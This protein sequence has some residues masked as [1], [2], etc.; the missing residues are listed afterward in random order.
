MLVLAPPFL[1]CSLLMKAPDGHRATICIA[2]ALAPPG[3]SFFIPPMLPECKAYSSYASGIPA[4]SLPRTKSTPLLALV[5]FSLGIALPTPPFIPARSS[6]NS[7]VLRQAALFLGVFHIALPVAPPRA[8]PC[9]CLP[10]PSPH[11][12][13]LASLNN[14]PPFVAPSPCGPLNQ[15]S[16]LSAARL[17]SL[18]H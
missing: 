15:V 3:A 6:P 14:T 16:T 7:Y 5:C 13:S 12:R 17:P 11:D 10:Y 18:P 2:D 4:P 9:S 8:S 1:T